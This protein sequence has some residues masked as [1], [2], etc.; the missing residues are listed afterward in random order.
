MPKSAGSGGH[1]S[2]NDGTGAGH[3]ICQGLLSK[4]IEILT[5]YIVG[6]NIFV[7]YVDGIL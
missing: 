7:Y 3:G 4:I 6:R 5:S 2:W 1:V